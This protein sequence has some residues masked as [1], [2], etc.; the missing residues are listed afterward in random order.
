MRMRVT[1]SVINRA[2]GGRLGYAGLCVAS[3][4]HGGKYRTA[5][6]QRVAG[7]GRMLM[8]ASTVQQ[9]HAKTDSLDQKALTR[10]KG[11]VKPQYSG[12]SSDQDVSVIF[13][14]GKVGAY[15]LPHRM[16]YAPLTR[17][18][19]MDSNPQENMVEYYRQRGV[20]SEGGLVIAE[21][22]VISD[23]GYGY[24]HTPGIHTQTHI[25]SWK[26]VTQATKHAGAVLFCQLWH[27]GRTSHSGDQHLIKCNA[28][29]VS[30][31]AVN[32]IRPYLEP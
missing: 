6:M 28:C 13:Q 29:A 9:E 22:T 8:T 30:V 21:G 19:A 11:N 10:Q 27:V 25:D 32:L 17:C 12:S 2:P 4:D 14:P 7:R 16:V 5:A 31:G 1:T 18:R 24:L 15:R 20:G 23:T 3:H 26:A